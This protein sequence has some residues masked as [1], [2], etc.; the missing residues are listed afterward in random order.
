[1]SNFQHEDQFDQLGQLGYVLVIV[2][3]A[4]LRP[5]RTHR[6]PSVSSEWL[7]LEW[8]E[9]SSDRSTYNHVLLQVAECHRKCE[10]LCFPGE[11][12]LLVARDTSDNATTAFDARIR[13]DRQRSGPGQP[14]DAG[15]IGFQIINVI[16]MLPMDNS[17][18]S[19]FT[20]L[21]RS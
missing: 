1:L 3:G 5:V 21:L 4:V 20:S 16:A 12:P 18:F 19:V 2:A 15:L 17:S 10:T 7:Q 9:L 14:F 6:S 13:P 8:Y 11:Y